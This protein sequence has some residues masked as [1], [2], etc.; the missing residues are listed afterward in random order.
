M[1]YKIIDL[2]CPGCGEP[3]KT[4]RRNCKYCGRQVVISSFNSVY[5][6]SVQDLNKYT[7]T[8][9]KALNEN[10]D[11]VELSCSIGMCYLKLKLYD[12]AYESFEK[13][14][15][16][17]FD[18]SEIYFYAAV[19]LLKGKKAFL[20][21]KSDIDKSID[22]TNAALM[23]ENRGIYNYFLAYLKYDF[24]SRKSLNVF[25]NYIEELINAREN[26]VTVNDIENLFNLLGVTTPEALMF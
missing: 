21:R 1:A 8:Y 19:S 23:I 26:S 13:A 9:K 4:D 10:P 5:D 12:K 18:N 14:I 6:M 15:E 17:N 2:K 25:P 20:A 22:L 3:V 24:Y 7:N 11:N 16:G